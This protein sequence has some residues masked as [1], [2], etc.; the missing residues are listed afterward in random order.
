MGCGGSK[1]KRRVQPAYEGALSWSD[2]QSAAEAW[3]AELM[4]HALKLK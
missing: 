4:L 1:S 3:Y 2:I